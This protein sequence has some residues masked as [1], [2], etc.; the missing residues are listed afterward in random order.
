M[1]DAKHPVNILHRYKPVDTGRLTGNHA[2]EDTEKVYST[3]Q[4]IKVFMG[5]VKAR[6]KYFIS[7]SQRLSIYLYRPLLVQKA[8]NMLHNKRQTKMLAIRECV[9]RQQE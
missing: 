7:I 1:V 6:K 4:E 9:T 2:S 5:D 8:T 3:E